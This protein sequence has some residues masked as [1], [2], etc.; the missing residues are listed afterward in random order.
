[1]VRSFLINY[2]KQLMFLIFE[3]II[4]LVFGKHFER[5]IILTLI[6][7]MDIH[8]K[9][10]IIISYYQCNIALFLKNCFYNSLFALFENYIKYFCYLR[11]NDRFIYYT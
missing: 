11:I 3:V 2:F 9:L 7:R 5:F 10:I 4:R 8:F 1:M 6:N